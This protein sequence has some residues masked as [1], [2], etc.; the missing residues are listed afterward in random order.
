VPLRRPIH[1]V[2]LG[3]P[4]TID[5]GAAAGGLSAARATAAEELVDGYL[6]VSRPWLAHQSGSFSVARAL[7]EVRY[8]PY[9]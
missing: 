9:R 1:R 3:V 4:P 2:A 8:S 7:A 6:W 5:V